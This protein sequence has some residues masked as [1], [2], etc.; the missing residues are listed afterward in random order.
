[1]NDPALAC[2]LLNWKMMSGFFPASQSKQ[3]S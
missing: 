1:M 2:A 3:P